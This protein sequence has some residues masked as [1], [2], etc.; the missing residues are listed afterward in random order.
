MV[1]KRASALYFIVVIRIIF[2]VRF[3]SKMCCQ[4]SLLLIIMLS[5]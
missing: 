3:I 2:V 5:I 1:D 4:L